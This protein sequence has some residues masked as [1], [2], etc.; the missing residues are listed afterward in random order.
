MLRRVALVG[1]D[2]SEERSAS[3]IRV[4][5]SASYVLPLIVTANFVPSSPI[6]VIL[7]MEVIHS[8]VMSVLTRATHNA[9]PDDDIFQY[10]C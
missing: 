6:L 7:M 9:I 3:I 5:V 10:H 4:R 8:S 1:T 2:V